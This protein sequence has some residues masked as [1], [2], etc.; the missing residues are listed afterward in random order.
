MRQLIE[1]P[2]TPKLRWLCQPCLEQTL[3]EMA[4]FKPSFEPS[5]EKP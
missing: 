2:N 4:A 3:K 1:L 5:G